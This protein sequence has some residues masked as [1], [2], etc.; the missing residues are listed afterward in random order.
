LSSDRPLPVDVVA[1]LIRRGGEVLICRRPDRGHLAGKWEFPGGKVEAGETPPQALAREI[2]EELGVECEVGP[3]V[4][5]HT[6]SYA[7]DRV[8]H[9][10]F[11]EAVIHGTPQMH[12][13]QAIRWVKPVALRLFDFVD[14]DGP[15]IERLARG[16]L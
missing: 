8:A 16:E 6:H 3:L 15:I 12:D 5:E 9:L 11:H 4:F 1:A 7:P 2:R 13:H 10:L 14:G